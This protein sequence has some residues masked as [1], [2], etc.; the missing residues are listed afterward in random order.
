MLHFYF[1]LAQMKNGARLKSR[2][3]PG[4]EALPARR[5]APANAPQANAFLQTLPAGR[6]VPSAGTRRAPGGHFPP[7]AGD[8]GSS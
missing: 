1:N 6:C 3:M 2:F 5:S 7:P 4:T 8:L